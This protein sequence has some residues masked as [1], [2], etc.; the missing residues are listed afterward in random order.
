[1]IRQLLLVNC[2]RWPANP[3]ELPAIELGD[4]IDIK[5]PKWDVRHG[6]SHRGYLLTLTLAQ[7]N[8]LKRGLV[9]DGVSMHNAGTVAKPIKL[10]TLL[11]GVGLERGG[12]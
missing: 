12:E 4:P 11:A 1:M 7:Y 3:Q 9:I 10:D 5:P 2:K 8:E 6:M